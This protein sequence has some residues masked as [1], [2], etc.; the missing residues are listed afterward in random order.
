MK[1]RL[2]AL[3]LTGLLALAAALPASSQTLALKVA[4]YVPANSPWDQGL[5]RLAAEFARISNGR[6]TLV[7][8]QSLKASTES[9]II[10]K[11]RLGV[12]G[13]LLTTMGIAEIYPD[14]LALSTPSLVRNDAELDAVLQSVLPIIKAKLSEKYVVLGIYKGGWIRY[15]STTPIVYPEDL[16]K[17]RMSTSPTDEKITRLLQSIGTRT[18]KGDM[19]ALI[20]QL[21]SNAVDSFYLSPIFVAALWSQLQGKISY[22]SSFKVCPFIGSIVFTKSSWD[23]VPPELRPRLEEAVQKIGAEMAANS[24]KLETA[25]IEALQKDGLKI[26]AYPADADSRWNKVFQEK[27][28]SVISTMFSADFL[29]AMD[30]ALAKA[31]KG[32]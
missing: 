27:R 15:F 21:N 19:S 9:D 17:L 20:L 4:S 23:K 31:R 30:A 26:P 6:V 16:A 11:M 13:A 7:F 28:E 1:A 3:A 5:K 32:K 8:P 24:D 25:S 10:Q 12:D 22:M 29:A 2:S 18:V 14:S